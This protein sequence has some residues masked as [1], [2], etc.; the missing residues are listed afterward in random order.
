MERFLHH[1]GAKVGRQG[2]GIRI[3]RERDCSFMDGESFCLW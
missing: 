3:S 2:V 1:V